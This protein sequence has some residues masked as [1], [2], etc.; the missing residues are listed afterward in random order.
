[1]KM[2]RKMSNQEIARLL[3]GMAAAYQIKGDQQFRVKA[4]EEAAV[5]VE[6][7][8][9]SVKDLWDDGK[10]ETLS[11][12]GKSIASY[13]DELFRTGKVKHFEK[14][15][16]EFPPAMFEYLKIPG[17][18]A[19][20]AYKLTKELKLINAS[21]EQLSLNLIV[22]I[23][24]RKDLSVE[25]REK[26]IWAHINMYFSIPIAP[27]DDQSEYTPTQYLSEL[28]KNKKYDGVI[29]R[30]A[31]RDDGCN[32]VLFDTKAAVIESKKVVRI[33]RILYETQ[34]VGTNC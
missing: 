1:M 33:K 24:N 20:T 5:S 26:L 13:L 8:T 16:G 23:G 4:Y 12:V 6:H 2:S 19:K 9:S 29:Y 27:E 30:S 15:M 34:L 11:G 7:A 31:I 18:G 17:V 10:L 32:V 22:S 21:K 25:D 28:F 14:V 3:K